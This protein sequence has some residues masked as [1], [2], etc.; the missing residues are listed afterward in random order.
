MC[1]SGRY[2]DNLQV[3]WSH[4]YNNEPC[5]GVPDALCP[6]ILGGE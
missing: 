2:L 3:D 5:Y 6:M 4:V 1:R